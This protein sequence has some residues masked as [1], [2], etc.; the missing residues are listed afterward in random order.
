[1]EIYSEN[2]MQE[3]VMPWAWVFPCLPLF[4]PLLWGWV[5]TPLCASVL[6]SVLQGLGSVVSVEERSLTGTWDVSTLQR[7]HRPAQEPGHLRGLC[8]PVQAAPQPG[9]PCLPLTW[10]RELDRPGSDPNS[11]P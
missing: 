9:I 6:Q 11:A 2:D 5:L 7:W 8:T 10:A 4:C 3:D 1:M